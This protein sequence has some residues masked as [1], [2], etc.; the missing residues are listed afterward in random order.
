LILTDEGVELLN[1]PHR[2]RK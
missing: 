2:I 1:W